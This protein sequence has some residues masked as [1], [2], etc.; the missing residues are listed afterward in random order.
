MLYKMDLLCIDAN[1]FSVVNIRL[2]LHNHSLK[3]SHR[4]I[5]RKV[6]QRFTIAIG[7]A[8]I[9][10]SRQALYDQHKTRFKGFIHETLDEYLHA[11]FHSTVFDTHEIAVYDED[12]LIAVSF[13]DLGER[14]MASLLALYDAEFSDY[15]LGTYTLLKEIEYGTMTGKKWYYPGYVLDQPSADRKS[16]RLNSSHSQQSRMPSSA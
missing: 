3:K 10:P 16:T 12:R 7:P 14:S 15:S 8:K 13:F 5:K 6:E 11:G 4:K 1:V 9:N 2:D